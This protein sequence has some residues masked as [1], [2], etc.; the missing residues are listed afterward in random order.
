M[1]GKKDAGYM[2][3]EGTGKSW[4]FNREEKLSEEKRSLSENAKSYCDVRDGIASF[5]I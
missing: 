4:K 2:G 5:F 3:R 1:K